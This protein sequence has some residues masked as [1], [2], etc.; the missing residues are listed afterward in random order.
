MDRIILKLIV[1]G[2]ILY[3]QIKVN[4][5]DKIV[6][7]WI[8]SEEIDERK[9]NKDINEY[10]EKKY[11]ICMYQSGKEDIR[12]NILDLILNNI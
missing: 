12:E 1:G 5:K 11:R 6:S 7:I 2:E 4:D 9:I 8:G 10:K 3:L